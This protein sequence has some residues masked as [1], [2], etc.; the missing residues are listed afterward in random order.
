MDAPTI[1]SA[2][3]IAF[4]APYVPNKIRTR[5]YNLVRHLSRLGHD[6]D[7]FTLGSNSRDEL[8]ALALRAHCRNVTYHEFPVWRSILNCLLALPTQVP[9]QSVYSWDSQLAHRLAIALNQEGGPYD[10]VHVEHLRGSKFARFVAGNHPDIPVVWDSVDCI[11]YLFEQARS[12][13]SNFFGNTITRFEVR[14][15]RRA[16]AE[17]IRMFNHV[18]TTSN[19]DKNALLG[20]LDSGREPSPIS[21]LPG[22]VDLEYFQPSPGIHA[23]ADT[24]V[25]SGKMSYHANVAMAVHLVEQIMPRI[26][27]RRPHVRLFIVG[28]DPGRKITE[29]AK[30]PLIHVTGTVEDIRPFL[31]RASVAVVPLVY[32]A[33]IQ[34]KI[35]EAMACGIP[36]VA[37]SR[38]LSALHVVA[39]RDILVGD[40]PLV[41]AD[42]IMQLLENPSLRTEVGLA[43]LNY[44]R[45]NHDWNR[46]AGLLDAIYRQAMQVHRSSRLP[47]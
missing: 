12:N 19:G 2:L 23:E 4:I 7:V 39:G 47:S 18:L 44:V 22:G 30:N 13:N 29:L 16:E 34:N 42:R 5:P 41:F 28:K 3:K 36:V 10:V 15:T 26:W 45:K 24:L 32:G 37:N 43:G 25:F 9:L 1:S 21:V 14:R 46:I 27:V 31:W 35:L 17:L 33:G 20:L 11:S 6:V 38:T 8:D 40:D